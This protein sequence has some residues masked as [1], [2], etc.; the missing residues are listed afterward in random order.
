MN[1]NVSGLPSQQVE[2]VQPRS[3]SCFEDV[4]P[5]ESVR[6]VVEEFP[7]VCETIISGVVQTELFALSFEEFASAVHLGS[8]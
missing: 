8:G 1:G 5:K 3:G 2:V 7:G 4:T 6:F